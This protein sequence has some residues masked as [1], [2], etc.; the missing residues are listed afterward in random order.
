MEARR[1]GHIEGEAAAL[2]DHARNFH[3]GTGDFATDLL[4]LA[5]CVGRSK[6]DQARRLKELEREKAWLRRAHALKTTSSNESRF[7]SIRL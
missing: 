1:R 2:R 5:E 6:L 7:R 3:A 4:P